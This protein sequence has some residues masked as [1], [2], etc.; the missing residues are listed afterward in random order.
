VSITM[1]E[2]PRTVRICGYCLDEGREE[3]RVRP[4]DDVDY[5][6]CERH[7][8]QIRKAL[9]MPQTAAREE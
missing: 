7:Q 6:T 8:A 9:R 3:P 4:C 5:G 1:T 2:P